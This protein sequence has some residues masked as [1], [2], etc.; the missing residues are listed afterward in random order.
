M[1]LAEFSS[2][3]EIAEVIIAHSYHRFASDA[4]GRRWWNGGM[5]VQVDCG[6]CFHYAHLEETQKGKWRWKVKIEK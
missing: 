2:L 4:D 1:E 6:Y 5:S 3:D